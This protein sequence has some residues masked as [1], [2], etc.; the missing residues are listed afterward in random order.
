MSHSS[1]DRGS[2][3]QVN[4]NSKDPGAFT[5]Q[6]LPLGASGAENT[7]PSFHSDANEGTLNPK[8]KQLLLTL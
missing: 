4:G 1:R 5:S 3:P 2:Q 7:L 6:P 8:R